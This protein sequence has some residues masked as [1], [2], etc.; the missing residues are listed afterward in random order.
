MKKHGNEIVMIISG[1]TKIS[2]L[3]KENEKSIEA[4]ASINKH[5]EKLRNPILRKI[6]ASRVT[7][8]DAAKIGNSSVEVF[9]QKLAPLGFVAEVLRNENSSN[10]LFD[11][12]LWNLLSGTIKAEM[13]VRPQI[14]ANNDPFNDIH[15]AVSKLQKGETLKIV[16]S[17]E[18][19]PLIKILKQKGYLVIAKIEN[20]VWITLI[21]KTASSAADFNKEVP[22]DN[23]DFD[24]ILRTNRNNIVN[25][26]VR[27][28]EMPKPMISILEKCSVLDAGQV[29]FVKHKRIPQFLFPEL[30]ALSL[31]WKLKVIDDDNVQILIYR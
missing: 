8:A 9:F 25:I 29:L 4:I 31:K 26:D 6:L 1:T 3:I 18:P 15:K 11:F 19:V 16:N 13:D 22:V 17:F 7:I 27:D 2:E 23:K 20:E 14:E 12:D 5:F 21:Q 10:T 30:A 24:D 28:M